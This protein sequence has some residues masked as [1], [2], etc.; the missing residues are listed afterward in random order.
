MR[1]QLGMM[2]VGSAIAWAM[3]LGPGAT[4][5]QVMLS[6]VDPYQINGYFAAPGLYGTAWGA[7]SVE[8]QRTNIEMVAGLADFMCQVLYLTSLKNLVDPGQ[9]VTIFPGIAPTSSM[10]E[11]RGQL[12]T[13]HP[14]AS[15]PFFSRARLNHR[16]RRWRHLPRLPQILHPPWG[17]GIGPSLNGSSA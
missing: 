4:R 16:P 3:L 8:I 6:G 11:G 1:R 5:A 7:P 10:S 15:C 17:E 2:I 14:V 9:H 12:A 13:G